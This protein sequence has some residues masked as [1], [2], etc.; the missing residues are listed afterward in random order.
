MA[1]LPQLRR[2]LV[3]QFP[4]QKAWI[5]SL[6]TVLNAFMEAVVG[7][8]NK[9]LTIVDNM[10]GDVKYVTLSNVPTPSTA[11][12]AVGPTSVAWT[13]R[14]LPIA[15]LVANVQQLSGA[16]LAAQTFALANAIQVQFAMSQDNKSLQITGV[17][18][19]TPTQAIQYRLTLICFT[20]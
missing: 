14:S 5:G 4:G 8:L 3:E 13:K 19:V 6:F 10:S 7:A 15:V 17:A 12:G 9:S 16:P 2:L 11:N 18:G 20:G 1:S